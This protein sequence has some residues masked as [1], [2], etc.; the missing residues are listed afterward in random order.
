MPTDRQE[1]P[2][3]VEPLAEG[4]DGRGDGA[5]LDDGLL[6]GSRSSLLFFFPL[7]LK[8]DE[9]HV[10]VQVQADPHPG[11]ILVRP[12]PSR[13]SHPQIVL[14]GVSLFLPFSPPFPID[15]HSRT[16]HGLYIDLPESFRRDYCLLWR[17][18]FTGDVSKIEDIAASWGIRR[19]NS[20][21]FASLTLLRPHKLKRKEKKTKEQ[22]EEEKRQREMTR[23]EQQAG[24]KDKLINMLE[25][26]ELIPRVRCCRLFRT[27]TVSKS[28]S[29]KIANSNSSSSPAP[30]E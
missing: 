2:G 14:I 6:M 25:S 26:E 21:I 20:N 8:T 17:S 12:H 30:C 11:N 22:E 1:A 5:F 28:D 23:Q 3:R 15:F 4:D 9:L 16:D 7:P 18:L 10:L 29:L 24:L 27:F 13:P 19:E